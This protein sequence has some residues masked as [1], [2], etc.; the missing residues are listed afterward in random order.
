MA[1]TALWAPAASSVLQVRAASPASTAPLESRDPSA[2]PAVWVRP[3]LL[4][5]TDATACEAPLVLV[6]HPVLLGPLARRAIRA[7]LGATASEATLAFP[8]RTASTAFRAS[9]ASVSAAPKAFPVLEDLQ[10]LMART[11]SPD[12]PAATAETATQALLAQQARAAFK[13]L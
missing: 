1:I 2:R 11:V 13:A 8:A 6:G 4:A 3:V 12:L 10:A 5:K 9:P 7:R